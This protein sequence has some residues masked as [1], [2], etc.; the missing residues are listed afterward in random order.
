MAISEEQIFKVNQRVEVLISNGTHLAF[1]HYSSRIEEIGSNYMIIAM[2]MNKGLPVILEKRQEFV[3]KIFDSTGVYSF[4][5]V[6]LDKKL[7]PIPI[8][9]TSNPFDL[10]KIQQR[11]FVRLDVAVPITIEYPSAEDPSKTVVLK[12]TTKDISGGGIQAISPVTLKQGEKLNVNINL[13]EKESLPFVGK[14]FVYINRK[15]I[16]SC[17]G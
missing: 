2:P 1:Q 13:S 10:K 11:A 5:S 14:L 12:A 7:N 6:F 16:V 15:M 4:K 17:F 3:G 8:W 9:V